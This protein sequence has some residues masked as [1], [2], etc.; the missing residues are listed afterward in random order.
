MDLAGIAFFDRDRAN[1]VVDGPVNG[2]VRQ[3]Y[4]KWNSVI[5]RSQGLEVR[6]DLVAH[7]AACRNAIGADNAHV[8]ELVLHQMPA[9]I[10]D[11]NGMRYPMLT[12]LPRGQSALVA[13]P[14]FVYPNMDGDSRVVRHV[15]GRQGGSPVDGCDPTG[16]AMGEHVEPIRFLAIEKAA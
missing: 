14:R 9:R 2:W 8:D 12:E 1:S 3:G 4:V 7:I 11:D 15:D 6:A 5:S 16:I 13:R 10:V